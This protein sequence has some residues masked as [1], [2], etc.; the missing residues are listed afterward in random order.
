M[1]RYWLFGLL[2]VGAIYSWVNPPRLPPRQPPPGT[3]RQQLGERV[4]YE[5]GQAGPVL[6]VLHGGASSPLAMEQL[7]GLSDCPLKVIYAQGVG[8]NWNDG[9]PDPNSAAAR[10]RIDDVGFIQQLN[11]RLGPAYLL[12]FSNGALMAGHYAAHHPRELKGLI[13]V[14]GGLVTGEELAAAQGLPVL[15]LQG[16][17]DPLVPYNGGELWG[18]RGSVLGA[19]QSAEA[20][21]RAGAQVT[22]EDLPGSDHDWTPEITRRVAGFLRL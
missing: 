9:R 1:G 7:T 5:H 12:G 6:I 21:R 13:C 10:Q 15:L 19:R 2:I 3:R 4:Y 18:N 17:K 16:P 22:L 14:R 8:G 20:W 11:S